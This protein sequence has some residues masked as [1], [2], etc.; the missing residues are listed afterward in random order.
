MAENPLRKHD[1]IIRA[2]AEEYY[3]LTQDQIERLG[4][5]KPEEEKNAKKEV[6]R[7]L[8]ALTKL[9]SVEG[10]PYFVLN[11]P[12][13]REP[14]WVLDMEGAHFP[15]KRPY[16]PDHRTDLDVEAPFPSPTPPK[17]GFVIFT[18]PKA[19]R[20]HE[21]E[22]EGGH[23]CKLDRKVFKNKKYI[24]NP[25]AGTSQALLQKD[26]EAACSNGATLGLLPDV[27][28]KEFDPSVAVCYIINCESF[29]PPEP[30]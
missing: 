1:V 3:K 20:D 21:R 23:V 30:W 13:F 4:K 22:A 18:V 10:G 14:Y 12:M 19:L 28:D 6:G 9:K 11:C 29:K 27:F 5:L 8:G 2:K 15:R 17:Y 26:I 24:W 25:P 7:F 16:P